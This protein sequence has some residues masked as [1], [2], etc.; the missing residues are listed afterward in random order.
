MNNLIV[1]GCS[2]TAGVIAWPHDTAEDWELKA[3]VWPHFCYLAQGGPYNKSFTNLAMPGGGNI[4]AMTNLILWLEQHRAKIESNNTLIGFNITGLGRW[5]TPCALDDP[6]ANLDLA[7][8][9]SQNLIHPSTILDLAWINHGQQYHNNSQH[10]VALLA[11]S[12][13]RS[14]MSYLEQ[15]GFK[16]FFMIMNQAVYD[17]APTFLRDAMDRRESQWVR[18]GEILGMAEF[19]RHNKAVTEDGHPT[20]LGHKLIAKVVIDHLKATYAT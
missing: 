3:S 19:V 14:C 17:F 20:I 10:H 12:C 5:D 16:Y 18:F 2:F 8:I 13:V 1:T 7:C 9:D 4:A 6:A 11:A 15:H